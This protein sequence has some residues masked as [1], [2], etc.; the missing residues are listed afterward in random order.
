MKGVHCDFVHCHPIGAAAFIPNVLP[1]VVRP[2]DGVAKAG[3]GSDSA[4]AVAEDTDV[5]PQQCAA[6]IEQRATYNDGIRHHSLETTVDDGEQHVGKKRKKHAKLVF[7]DKHEWRIVCG[8]GSRKWDSCL[9][10]LWQFKRCR[11]VCPN[12]GWAVPVEIQCAAEAG[13]SD[14]AKAIDSNDAR[15]SFKAVA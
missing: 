2:E 14:K 12:C 10:R 11:P 9:I 7:S 5:C 4:K 1:I 13:A 6:V 15:A 3:Q 8:C